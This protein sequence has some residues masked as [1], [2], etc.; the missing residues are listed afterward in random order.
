MMLGLQVSLVERRPD[1]VSLGQTIFNLE[2]ETECEKDENGQ[3]L[4]IVHLNHSNEDNPYRRT[5][6]AQ[7]MA[8]QERHKK[9]VEIVVEEE[10]DS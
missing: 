9:I 3:C 6:V 1:C 7:L 2:K 4:Q 10:I 5:I 8:Y